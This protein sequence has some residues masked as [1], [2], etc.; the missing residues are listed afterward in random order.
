MALVTV[1]PNWETAI[2]MDFK[3]YFKLLPDFK[4]ILKNTNKKDFKILKK[5]LDKSAWNLF[6]GNNKITKTTLLVSF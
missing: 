3:P 5:G 4:L 1:T 2:A 6:T